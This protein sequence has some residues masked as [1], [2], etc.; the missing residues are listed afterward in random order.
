MRFKIREYELDDYGE[1]VR[2]WKETRLYIWYMD[3]KPSVE[4]FW[5]ANKDLFLVAEVDG[6]VVG[7]VMGFHSGNF[8]LVYHLAVKPE[9]QRRGIGSRLLN[10][11]LKRLKARGAR[12][13]F[14]INHTSHRDALPFYFKQGFKSVGRFTGLYKVL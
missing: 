14:V 10:E 4:S 9:F 2:V 1:C 3:N 7:T 8:T 13:A 6:Q 11:I 12:F 5:K